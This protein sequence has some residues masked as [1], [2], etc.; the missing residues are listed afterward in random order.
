MTHATHFGPGGL[1]D[2]DLLS[3][4]NLNGR[5][6]YI[7]LTGDEGRGDAEVYG[8]TAVKYE[9]QWLKKWPPS[10][11]QTRYILSHTVSH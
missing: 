3:A 11:I 1:S 10:P 6:A 2:S 9:Q 5:G 8:V 4:V 7:I